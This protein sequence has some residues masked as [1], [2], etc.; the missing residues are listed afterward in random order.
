[1]KDNIINQPTI[2]SIQ[3]IGLWKRKNIRWENVDPHVNI[4]VGPNGSGKSTFL[5]IIN[6]IASASTKEL[7]KMGG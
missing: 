6:S 5:R 3:V 1:M 4:L 7:D 2:S